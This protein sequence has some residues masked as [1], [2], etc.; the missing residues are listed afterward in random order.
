MKIIFAVDD[1]DTNLSVVET[2]LCEEYSVYAMASAEKMFTLLKN[3]TP[4][5]ILLDIDMP[6]MNGLD[7]LKELKLSKWASI[8][9]IFLSAHDNEKYEVT[10]LELGAVDFISKPF[11]TPILL[12]RIKNH[13][14]IDEIIQKQTAKLNRLQ[15]SMLS[16]ITNLLGKRD[17]GTG[18]H[19]ERTSKYIKILIEEMK[20]RNVYS[21]ILSEWDTDLITSSARLH[22]LGKISIK[23][24]ILNKPGKLTK[25]EFE[26]IKAHSAEGE[27]IINEII[28]QTGDEGFLYNAKI[29]A[30]S[31][32]ERWNGSGY[33]HG[34]KGLT[35][36]LQG[37]I[38]AIVDVYDALVSERPYKKAISHDDAV[39]MIMEQSGI[40]YDP[41]ICDVFFIINEKLKQIHNN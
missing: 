39:K 20:N 24:K 37:R 13:I 12:N 6:V 18:G 7:A 11:S 40:H 23:D 9:V 29:F 25:N 35:I 33:P 27:R 16:V 10:G 26:K 21:E 41:K 28:E 31:H 8:P 1:S 17:Y 2:A 5:L 36:P 19:I 30:I 14:R 32:H 34:H 38:M 4:E 15:I 3:I 22:D